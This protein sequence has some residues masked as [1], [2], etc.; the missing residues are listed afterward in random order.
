MA[1]I[2]VGRSS[3]GSEYLNY[4]YFVGFRFL[5]FEVYFRRVGEFRKFGW[6]YWR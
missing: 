2:S 3:C 5:S 1:G 4:V 6:F